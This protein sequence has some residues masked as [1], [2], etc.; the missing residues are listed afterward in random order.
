MQSGKVKTRAIRGEGNMKKI[1]ECLRF[2]LPSGIKATLRNYR[3]LSLELGQFK[4]MQMWKPIDKDNHPIPWFTYP[5]IEYINQ[6]DLSSY[7]IFEYGSG[8]SS[9]Y[10]AER[11]KSLT[12]IEDSGIWHSKMA[13]QM[14]RKVDYRLCEDKESYIR[15]IKESALFYDLIV[16]DG[17][18]RFDCA[19]EAL[20]KLKNTG[21]MIVD[22]TESLDK[23]S[24]WLRA[25]GLIEVDMAGF[26]P[27]NDYTWITS[28]F[29]SRN[30]LLKPRLERQPT[31]SIGG[32]YRVEDINV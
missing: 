11:C 31:T 25:Q 16:I 9:L 13:P 3:T 15:S 30:V 1:K 7:D 5:S 6:L 4:S 23:T 22:N 21:F 19:K 26:G 12:S 8:Y 2:L 28:F 18:H 32:A 10:W 20:P 14:P 24:A 17:S 27:L 29:F